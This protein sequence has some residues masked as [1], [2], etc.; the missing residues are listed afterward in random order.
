MKLPQV[1]PYAL[2][3]LATLLAT[4]AEM[5]VDPDFNAS[6]NSNGYVKAIAVNSDGLTILAGEFTSV[7][8]TPAPRLTRVL[9]N[10]QVDS[11]FSVGSGP[12]ASVECLT[13]NAAGEIVIG[14]AFNSVDGVEAFHLA[15]LLTGGAVDTTFTASPSGRVKTVAIASDGQI[16]AG[17]PF[18]AVDGEASSYVC[19]LDDLGNGESAFASALERS[20]AIEAGVEALAVQADGKILVGG[21]FNTSR[22]YE[23]LVRLHVDG[24]L[25]ESFSQ[26]HGPILYTRAILPLANG[27]TLVAGVADPYDTGFVRRLNGDGTVDPS[28][29]APVF[30]GSVNALALLPNGS[31]VVGSSDPGQ[32]ISRLLPNGSPDP[33][34]AVDADA[35]VYSLLALANGNVLVGGAFTEIGGVAQTGIARLTE[36]TLRLQALA[37]SNA[38]PF[39][40]QLK[41]LAGKTYIVESSLDLTNWDTFSTNTATNGGLEIT[42]AGVS[43]TA[44]RFFRAKRID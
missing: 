41:A 36:R 32:Y 43:A 18:H 3:S 2:L 9:S 24:S 34:W 16:I 28:F 27:Q 12:D 10:G 20:F 33:S 15:K 25:D 37:S 31:I 29:S 23:K 7:N 22:G 30:N 6:I 35:P 13:L 11:S 40:I 19:R 38:G 21:V 8:G 39:R 42:D 4:R 17:G 26:D 14:G 5:V 1:P 44:H